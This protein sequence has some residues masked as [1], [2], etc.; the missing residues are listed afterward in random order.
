MSQVTDCTFGVLQC[1]KSL[2]H[3]S[4]SNMN[5]IL[6]TEKK[7]DYLFLTY[8]SFFFSFLKRNLTYFCIYQIKKKPSRT[9]SYSVNKAVCVQPRRQASAQGSLVN[10]EGNP[11]LSLALTSHTL[12]RDMW[13]IIWWCTWH[14]NA[15][16]YSSHHT[17]LE[18]QFIK[19]T[20]EILSL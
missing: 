7:K 15:S 17:R 8:L 19:W 20:N 14:R 6:E 1:W 2:L 5:I 13:C 12:W 16:F 9:Q 3:I 4:D 11:S 10:G 18:K